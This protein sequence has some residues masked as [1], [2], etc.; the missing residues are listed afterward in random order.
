MACGVFRT[1][2]YTHHVNIFS[3]DFFYSVNQLFYLSQIM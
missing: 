2:L 1:H 3:D